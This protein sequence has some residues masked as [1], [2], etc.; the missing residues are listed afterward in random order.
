MRTVGHVDEANVFLDE[1]VVCQL[2]GIEIRVRRLG[3][4]ATT[5]VDTIGSISGRIRYHRVARS[6]MAAEIEAPVLRF[7]FAFILKDLAEDLMGRERIL[8]AMVDSK[9]VCNVLSMDDH[10]T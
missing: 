4:Y 10:T 2:S 5:P 6:V 1:L 7:D 8:E 9:T 3:C